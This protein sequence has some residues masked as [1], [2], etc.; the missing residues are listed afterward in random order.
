MRKAPPKRHHYVPEMLQKHFTDDHGFLFAFLRNHSYRG[1]LQ[2]KPENIF[3]EG[4]LY[5]RV[6]KMVL[7]TLV[8]KQS[9]HSLKIMP[10][11]LSLKL[12]TQ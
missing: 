5:R 9:F 11:Q 10:T 12:S 2:I 8:W 3:L 1:I 6:E 7:Q 4:H